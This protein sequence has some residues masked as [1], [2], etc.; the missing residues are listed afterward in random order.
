MTYQRNI[1][2]K[3]PLAC[4]A[5]SLTRLPSAKLP[6]LKDGFDDR[7]PDGVHQPQEASGDDH[8]S[9]RDGGALTGLAPV[10]P[11]DAPQLV[12]HVA[13][14]GEDLAALA[15]GLAGL[16]ALLDDGGIGR[17]DV[18]VELA[19]AGLGHA[20]L[21]DVR[22]GMLGGL[23][24]GGR[25]ELGVGR[26]EADITR[27]RARGPRRRTAGTR[28]PVAPPLLR[29]L[30]IA[31]HGEPPLSGFPVAG[32]PPAPLAVLAQRDAI[33]VVALG[34][35][36]LIVPALALLAREGDGDPD[37]ST[38]HVAARSEGR[39]LACRAKKN[40]AP[41]RGR[42]V[43]IAQLSAL[44]YVAAGHDR[45]L[46]LG[47]PG[48]DRP[49]EPDELRVRPRE[50]GRRERPLPRRVPRRRPPVPCLLGDHAA[51]VAGTG[52]RP[53]VRIGG[54]AGQQLV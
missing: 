27:A 6:F 49:G 33:G 18:L 14:E 22:E 5:K 3:F 50:R 28:L 32:V 23:G 38:G 1:R 26:L 44:P 37:V 39:G 11:L 13:E 9:E 48:L 7:L 25:V 34:L 47:G 43:R 12:D 35:I 30:S 21:L 4:Q 29:A 41:A 24:S 40:P 8:E 45:R 2:V 16:L 20:R 19:G 46:L 42:Q 17:R 15:P 31:G 54:P 10:R 51:R 53:Q 52:H 36:G